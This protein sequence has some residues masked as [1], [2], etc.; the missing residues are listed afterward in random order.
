MFGRLRYANS[1]VMRLKLLLLMMVAF[2]P[3]P[4]RLMAEAIRD[5]GAE[6]AAV[7]F[8]GIS[9]FVVTAVISALWGSIARDRELLKPEVSEQEITAV[10]LA[11]TPN[12]ALFLGA[13]ASGGKVVGPA[14]V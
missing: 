5:S 8:Y 13:I 7:V 2:L 6:R 1:T 10:T 12:T 11:A 3:F 14:L 9:L 4:T